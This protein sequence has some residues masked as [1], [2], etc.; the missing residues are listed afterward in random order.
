MVAEEAHVVGAEI[1]VAALNVCVALRF[2][3]LFYF[4]L[5]RMKA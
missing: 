5:I 3:V 4:N 1:N 2:S